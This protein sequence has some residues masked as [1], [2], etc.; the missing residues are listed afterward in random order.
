MLILSRYAASGASSRLRALQ[1][2]PALEARGARVDCAPL[3]SEYYLKRY[4]NGNRSLQAI[5]IAYAGRI[6]RLLDLRRYSVIW[7]EKE[8]L[9]YFPRMFDALLFAADRPFIVDFDDAIFHKYDL[10]PRP[11]VRR[12]FS[13]RLDGLLSRARTVTVG[14][15]YLGAYVSAHGARDVRLL[16]TV[17]DPARYPCV[18]EPAGGEFRIAWIGSPSTAKYLHQIEEALTRLASRLPIR[19]VTIGSPAVTRFGA[20]IEQHAWSEATEGEL[21]S[22][23]HVGIMP[24]ADSP[25]E[26]GKCGYKLVQ[27]MAA[28]RPVVASPIGVNVDIVSPEVGYLATTTDDW[29]AKLEQLA[30]DG[31]LRE[32]M[33]HAGRARVISNYSLQ[34]IGSRFVDILAEATTLN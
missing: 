1:F 18:P 6:A 21:L 4:N 5:V 17:V 31:M 8:L 2:I 23:C 20:P 14:N 22:R 16:P 12:L 7:I 19:L 3:F 28:G 32:R 26:R 13:S 33:G 15:N 25:W 10:H 24:L 9:P 29:A 11:V 30:L 27:Y 34:A